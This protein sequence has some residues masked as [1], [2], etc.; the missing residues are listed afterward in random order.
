MGQEQHS[1]GPGDGRKRV[2]LIVDDELP[3]RQLLKA[4]IEGTGIPCYI[5][6]AADGDTA[7]MLAERERHDLV[8]LDIVMP[9]SSISGVLVARKLIEELRLN[10]A[11]VS[12]NAVGSI[13]DSCL[14]MGAIDIIRKPFSVEDIREKFERWLSA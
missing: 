8:L 10:V 1:R 11:I 3:M 12:A 9:D 6:E 4:T 13:A 14:R 5:F 7:V 2:V